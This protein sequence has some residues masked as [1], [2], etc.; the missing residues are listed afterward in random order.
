VLSGEANV[1]FHKDTGGGWD[2]RLQ[3]ALDTF[4]APAVSVGGVVIVSHDSGGHTSFGLGA[5]AG[6]NLNF[7]DHVGWWPMGG[8][9]VRHDSD[10]MQHTSSTPASFHLFAPFLYHI[11][12]HF[13][14]GLGPSFDL[15]LS[16]SH[17]TIGV[18]SIVGGWF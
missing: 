5:R 11:V 16:D 17:K 6:Y 1:G 14:A 7:S 2:I 9:N 12:P 8:I 13:F 18:D 3:P 15:G 10:S 4:I